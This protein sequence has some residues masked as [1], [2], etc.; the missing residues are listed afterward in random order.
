ML[1][2]FE[3]NFIYWFC[4]LR[5]HQVSEHLYWLGCSVYL[6]LAIYTSDTNKMHILPYYNG[7]LIIHV[8]HII[9]IYCLCACQYKTYDNV[10]HFNN[11]CIYLCW[12]YRNLHATHV[13]FSL[14]LQYLSPVSGNFYAD[15]PSIWNW[16][17]KLTRSFERE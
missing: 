8:A 14:M 12:L 16:S 13:T 4:L 2:H 15:G 10:I 17:V 7:T 11:C 6:P 9:E 5:L 1:F 3:I